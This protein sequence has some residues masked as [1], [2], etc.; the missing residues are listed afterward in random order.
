MVLFERFCYQAGRVIGDV[1]YYST[2][3]VV[4]VTVVQGSNK[5]SRLATKVALKEKT[6]EAITENVFKCLE[7]LE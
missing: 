4:L 7:Y 1:I 2:A 6:R 3:P 5:F